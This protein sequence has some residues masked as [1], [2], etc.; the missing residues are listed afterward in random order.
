MT[1][2]AIDVEN[3]SG[4]CQCGDV[5]YEVA[6]GPVRMILCHCDMCRHQTGSPLPGFISVPADRVV[7]T[8]NATEY[9]SSSI[10]K[11][12]FCNKCGT[13]LFYRHNDFDTIGL[14]AGTANLDFTPTTAYY[15]EER[16][17]WLDFLDHLAHKEF[18]GTEDMRRFA[19]ADQKP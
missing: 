16:A 1:D 7:W 3:F 12:G 15:P 11:R 10:A 9:R 6:G 13:P 2:D 17:P 19:D 18:A 8:G 5:H 14:T 4:G